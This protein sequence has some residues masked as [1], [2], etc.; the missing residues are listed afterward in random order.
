MA[1]KT[2]KKGDLTLV[3]NLDD[4]A[5]PVALT[6]EQHKLLQAFGLM[7]GDIKIISDCAVVYITDPDSVELSE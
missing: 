1:F 3:Y 4:K 5:H 2:A 7:L 6:S